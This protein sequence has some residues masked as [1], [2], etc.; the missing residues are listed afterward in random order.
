MVRLGGSKATGPQLVQ[1]NRLL[2]RQI[3]V[4]GLEDCPAR[5]LGKAALLCLGLLYLRRQTGS[6]IAHG[7]SCRRHISERLL[8]C[9]QRLILRGERKS[10]K[11]IK[12]EHYFRLERGYGSFYRRLPLPVSIDPDKIKAKFQ[13]GV[14]EVRMPKPTEES[15]KGKRIAVT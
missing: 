4:L 3:T 8:L 14:L 12:E 13:E 10:E 15:P 1:G 2:R 7:I 6:A 5:A 11:E 9:S